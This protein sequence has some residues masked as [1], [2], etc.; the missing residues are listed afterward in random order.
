MRVERSFFFAAVIAGCILL[1][2]IVGFVL[3]SLWPQRVLVSWLLLGLVVLVILVRL[4]L[5]VI[6]TGTIAKVRLSEEALRSG[7]LYAH[8]RLIEEEGRYHDEWT[9]QKQQTV[10]D[11]PYVQHPFVYT[12]HQQA[13][14]PYEIHNVPYSGLKPLSIDSYDWEEEK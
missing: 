11:E 2:P 9:A 1:L 7:R 3:T 8:E 10:M 6:K 4:A 5:W 14:N 12:P 13:P